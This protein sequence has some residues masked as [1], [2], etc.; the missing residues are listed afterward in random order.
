MFIWL[1]LYT[2][3][4]TQFGPPYLILN[5]R[6]LNHPFMQTFTGHSGPVYAVA[7]SPADPRAMLTGGGDDRAFLWHAA[8]LPL[9]PPPP[10]GACYG[11]NGG[12]TRLSTVHCRDQALA[13]MVHIYI[14]PLTLHPR[15]DL[16]F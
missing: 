12:A 13:L 5:P 8:S 15:L 4:C 2:C 10:T 14:Y 11:T 6:L 16:N 3:A 9:P 7:I 1:Y